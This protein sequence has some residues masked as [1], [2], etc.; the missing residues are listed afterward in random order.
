MSPKQCFGQLYFCSG[1][2]ESK[3]GS[4]VPV[5]GRVAEA[6]SQKTRVA[7]EGLFVTDACEAEPKTLLPGRTRF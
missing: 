4:G 2:G 5:E 6:G 1:Q 3:A 7:D